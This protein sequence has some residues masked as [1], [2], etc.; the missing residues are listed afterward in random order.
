M[1][2]EIVKTAL[3][4]IN[5][6]GTLAIGTWLYLEKR[7]DKTNARIDD[8]EKTLKGHAT[9]LAKLEVGSE[10]APTHADLG[11]LHERISAVAEGVSELTGEFSGVRR[12][13]DLIHEYLLKGNGR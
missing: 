7:S 10:N 4:V 9:K 11:D 2:L 6:L 13:L 1:D 12:T 5:M 8:A 3:M